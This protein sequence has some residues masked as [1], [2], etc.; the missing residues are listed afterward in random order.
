MMQKHENVSRRK[1]LKKVA[2][3]APTIVALGSLSSP[4]NAHTN[5]STFC[6]RDKYESTVYGNS[7]TGRFD[8]YKKA[9]V[10]V[11]GQ[12]KEFNHDE[13]VENKDGFFTFAK[14]WFSQIRG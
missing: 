12:F 13:V 9:K 8:S 4:A 3:T 5:T 14:K 11:N 1:F 7:A 10:K 6:S 2:Y